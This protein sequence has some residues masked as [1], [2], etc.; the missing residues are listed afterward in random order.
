MSIRTLPCGGHSVYIVICCLLVMLS[1]GGCAS[2]VPKGSEDILPSTQSEFPTQDVTAS[3]ETQGPAAPPREKET[4][5]ML[6]DYIPNLY[7]D[8][9]YSTED[10]F[11]NTVIYDFTE[12]ELR[13]GTVEKLSAAQEMLAAQ[14]YSLKIWDAYRPVAAQFRLWEVCPDAR[15]V[16]NPE[17]GYSSHSRGNTVDVTLVRKDGE[18]IEMP[19]GFDEFSALGDRDYSDVS[20]TAGEHA[21][22]LESVMD[23]CGFEGYSG[24]WW[25]YTDRDAYPVVR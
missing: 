8:L 9:K 19:S 18:E 24:E 7:I 5:V 16:A 2:G 10:N 11:T 3:Q 22:L 25:H 20:E 23:A 1:F 4:L 13:Y 21:R 14:G 15:Y 12:P 17:R 6:R